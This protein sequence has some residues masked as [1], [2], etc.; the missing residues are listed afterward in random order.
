MLDCKADFDISRYSASSILTFAKTYGDNDPLYHYPVNY[1]EQCNDLVRMA[2]PSWGLLT[3]NQAEV[4][5]SDIGFS[6]Y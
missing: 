4:L 6:S 2:V 3:S 5:L 1:N